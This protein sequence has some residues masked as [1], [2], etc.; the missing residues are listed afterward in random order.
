LSN[1]AAKYGLYE[2]G[3]VGDQASPEAFERSAG[4]LGFRDFPGLPT[5]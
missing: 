3:H 4:A 2:S 5:G 1:Y